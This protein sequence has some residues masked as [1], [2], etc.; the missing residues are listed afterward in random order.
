MFVQ[1]NCGTPHWLFMKGNCTPKGSGQLRNTP[2]TFHE[3]KLHPKCFVKVTQ[4]GCT[5]N[6]NC[7]PKDHPN[8][9]F[10]WSCAG[11]CPNRDFGHPG[12]DLPPTLTPA[13]R[14]CTPL[15]L[16]CT[17]GGWGAPRTIFG[18]RPGQWWR[19]SHVM[20]FFSVLVDDGVFR[21]KYHYRQRIGIENPV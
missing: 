15:A 18:P 17:P 13:T 2:L 21:M 20:N 10:Y 19:V 7:T 6:G 1:A 9:F 14:G 3:G 8:Q 5:P 4:V 11:V 16:D 12:T